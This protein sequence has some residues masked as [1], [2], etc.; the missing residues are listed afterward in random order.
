MLVAALFGATA[1][2]LTLRDDIGWKPGAALLVALLAVAVL[3]RR[4]CPLKS[5]ALAFLSIVVLDG[6]SRLITGEM[7]DL[8]STVIVLVIPYAL[9]RW[10]SGR[11]AMFGFGLIIAAVVHINAVGWTGLTDAIGG[12]IFL[13]FPAALGDIVR[14]QQQSRLQSIEE[15]KLRE[16][17]QLAR[18]LH[19]TVAHHVSAIAIQAQAGQAVASHDPAAS[20][21]FLATIE[22]EASRT[23]LE[24][25]TMVGALRGGDEPELSPQPGVAQIEHLAEHSARLPVTLQTTG[26]LTDLSPP[27]DRALFRLAQES[28]TN[29]TRHARNATNVAVSIDVDDDRVRLSVVDDGDPRSFDPELE[30]GFGLVGMTER[31]TLLGGSLEAGPNP[32]RGWTVSAVLPKGGHLS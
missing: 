15:V 5:T 8:Y 28:I 18:E 25:R 32:Q 23:L 6:V 29:A 16:R 21:E 13:L 20:L 24:M 14:Y 4:T 30:R 10:A 1:V 27:V 12:L 7:I 11:D 22:A 26:D 19:D 9:V 3:W 17:E 2:E 31:A